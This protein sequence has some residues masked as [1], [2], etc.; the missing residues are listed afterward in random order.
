MR[1]NE[2]RSRAAIAFSRSANSLGSSIQSLEYFTQLIC[3]KSRRECQ[4]EIICYNSGVGVKLSKMEEINK[5][6]VE[7]VGKGMTLP[8]ICEALEEFNQSHVYKA[9]YMALA[10][11]HCEIQRELANEAYEIV[12]GALMRNF[13]EGINS[14][15]FRKRG[16]AMKA[17]ALILGKAKQPNSA[18]PQVLKDGYKPAALIAAEDS[19]KP[20]TLKE[21]A[22]YEADRIK[23]LKARTA[24]AKPKTQKAG[25]LN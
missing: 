5:R 8:Q 13:L 7:M 11:Q 22:E 24:D 21:R 15:D 14:E 9:Y 25:V 18:T 16:D 19:I 10:A 6:V 2:V 3:T 1:V 23:A 20:V 4:S 12:S 17:A